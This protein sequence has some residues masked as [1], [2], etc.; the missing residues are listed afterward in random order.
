MT[1][2]GG[3][4][5]RFR[6]DSGEDETKL[7]TPEELG[8]DEPEEEPVE[9]GPGFTVEK[10]V[11]I[12]DDLPPD[13]SRESALHIVRETLVAAGVD[14]TALERQSRARETKLNSE[15]ALARGRREDL[16]KRADEVLGSLED[17]IRKAREARDTGVTAEEERISRARKRLGEVR[18][19]RA[20]F[21]FP[22]V[23]DE[24]PEEDP[25]D[26]TQ[27]LEGPILPEQ[28]SGTDPEET[29]VLP[30]QPRESFPDDPKDEEGREGGVR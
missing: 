18:R 19:V 22:E 8:Q 15:V 24:F 17:E 28:L 29:Q 4:F 20:F 6:A 3:F 11:R 12:V 2:G 27:V 26:E 21:G 23:E 16:K 13:V 1:R 10:A 25:S 9:E 5:G 7:Y 14:L 30:R